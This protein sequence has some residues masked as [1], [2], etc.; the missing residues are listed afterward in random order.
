MKKIIEEKLVVPIENIYSSPI[1][2]W[3]ERYLARHSTFT[4]K[5]RRVQELAAIDQVRSEILFRLFNRP[6]SIY[7]RC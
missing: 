1:S 2:E 4:L 6:L 5:Q 3:L 7:R